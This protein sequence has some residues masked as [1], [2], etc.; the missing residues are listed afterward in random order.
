MSAREDLAAQLRLCA[1]AAGLSNREL[2][3]RSGYSVRQVRR[4]LAGKEASIAAIEA[5]A[6]VLRVRLSLVPR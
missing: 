3:D 2:A 5:L 4:I 6:T 1:A